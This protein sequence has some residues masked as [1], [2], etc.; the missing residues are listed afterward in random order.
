M[1]FPDQKAIMK[2]T[3]F[4]KGYEKKYPMETFQGKRVFGKWVRNLTGIEW[5]DLHKL[6]T[7]SDRVFSDADLHKLVKV[8][9][10]SVKADQLVRFCGPSEGFL[11]IQVEKEPESGMLYEQYLLAM[12]ES[13]VN[14]CVRMIRTPLVCE[15]HTI[16]HNNL[17]LTIVEPDTHGNAESLAQD[18]SAG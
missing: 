17:R 1:S 6:S 3:E 15:A 14:E 9:T 13:Y 4:T 12:Y 2:F 5:Q 8:V 7:T 10:E 11:Y 16:T 18:V